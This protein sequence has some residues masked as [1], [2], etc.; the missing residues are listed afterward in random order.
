MENHMQR[1]HRY[2]G[3]FLVGATL[4]APMALIAA[5][6]PQ[7]RE[8]KKEHQQRYYDRQHKDYHVWNKNED[9]SFNRWKEEKHD[10]TNRSFGKMKRTEQSEYWNWRHEH[11]DNDGDRK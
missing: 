8:E 6:N 5:S 9:G 3:V 4:I 11:P 1:I 10:Q 2:M 7:D